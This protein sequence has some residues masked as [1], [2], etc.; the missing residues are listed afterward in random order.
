MDL[1]TLNS[2][3]ADSKGWLNP[4]VGSL[5]A[6]SVQAE[7]FSAVGPTGIVMPAGG[8]ITANQSGMG[9]PIYTL[10]SGT[11]SDVSTASVTNGL[12]PTSKLVVGSTYE[13]YIAGRFT[14]TPQSAGALQFY[15]SFSDTITVLTTS[16]NMTE[17]LLPFDSLASQKSFELRF[18]FRVITFTDTTIQCQTAYSGLTSAAQDSRPRVEVDATPN[19]IT[20]A[21]RTTNQSLRFKVFSTATDMN[22]T[23]T[24]YYVRQI[25]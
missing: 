12:I 4:V 24:Q 17:V 21:S 18:T 2:G 7:S 5:T 8:T 16:N 19:T 9:S 10:V 20:T 11:Y 14:E 22:L 23:R 6:N 13:V 1:N 3:T 15:P 25:C